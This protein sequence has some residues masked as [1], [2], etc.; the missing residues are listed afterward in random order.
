MKGIVCTVSSSITCSAVVL[1]LAEDP[2]VT[3]DAL[4]Q[5]HIE[6]DRELSKEDSSAYCGGPQELLVLWSHS[7]S[8]ALIS[9]ASKSQ[10]RPKNVIRI[11]SGLNMMY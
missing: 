2:V 8:I 11:H 10:K 1:V 3:S 7:P 6:P 5:T 9:Y 4:C